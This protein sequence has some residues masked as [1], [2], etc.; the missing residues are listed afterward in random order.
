M[1]TLANCKLTEFCAQT[2]ICASEIESLMHSI[3]FKGVLAEFRDK[4]SDTEADEDTTRGL[5]SD[6]FRKLLRDHP[7]EVVKLIASLAFMTYDEAE[8]LSPV[9]ALN[10]LLECMFSERVV[11]FFLSLKKLEQNDSDPFF[12][13]LITL[14]A[15]ILTS[16]DL[17]QEK[18]EQ[19]SEQKAEE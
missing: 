16:K 11:D 1:K 17:S 2:D 18:S 19:Y 6:V 3:D 8:E 13:L 15:I 4:Y 9:D 5:I 12:I 14:K 10:V 7:E